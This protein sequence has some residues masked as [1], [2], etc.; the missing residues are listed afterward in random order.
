MSTYLLTLLLAA[1]WG[2]VTECCL[3]LAALLWYAL[4]GMLWAVL[5]AAGIALD[6]LSWLLGARGEQPE[7]PEQPE[8]TF[9]AEEVMAILRHVREERQ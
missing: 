1:S 6:T 5:W 9:S 2:I 7:Q 4:Q 3:I 8:Q